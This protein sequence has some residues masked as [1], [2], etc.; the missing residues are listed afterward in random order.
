MRVLPLERRQP[1][2][3]NHERL[4]VPLFF[5]LDLCIVRTCLALAYRMMQRVD[6][7]AAHT[8]LEFGADS[9]HAG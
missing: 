1:R 7:R 8:K 6:H 4:L 9:G 2:A 5:E 3:R